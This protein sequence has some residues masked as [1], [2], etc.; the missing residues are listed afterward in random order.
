MTIDPGQFVVDGMTPSRVETPANEAELSDIVSAAHE[1]GETIIPS[2]GR[3]GMSLGN[4]PTGYNVAANLA[5]MNGIVEYEPAD[6]TIVV[7][8]GLTFQALQ[9]ELAKHGQWLPYDPAFDDRATIGGALATNAVGTIRG[10]V[11]GI[12][13]LT[14]GLKVVEAD[15][16]ITKSGGKVVKNVQG[17]DLVRLHTGALGTLGVIVE[18]AF[19]V[20]PKPA[21]HTAVLSWV[22]SL[23]TARS[24]GMSLFNGSFMP[25]K[26]TVHSGTTAHSAI[27]S[28]SGQS[29]DTSE[30]FLIE[31]HLAGG[32]K[33][34]RRQVD[35]V[36][37]LLGSEM[38]EGYEV[39]DNPDDLPGQLA[40]DA[41]DSAGNV[42]T[43]G[44]FKPVEAFNFSDRSIGRSESAASQ[45]HVA[46]G[47]VLS[48]WNVSNA[49]SFDLFA[50]NVRVD[51]HKS[52]ARLV[53]DRCPHEYKS[54]IDV[55]DG[56]G[57]ELEISRRMK[58]Q[59]DPSGTLNPGRFVA[60]I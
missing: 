41:L 48:S 35:E 18:A 13:D 46:T 36:T 55:W 6:L 45:L 17:F 9:A 33:T 40:L 47:T 19:K 52:G 57:Q 42:A 22:D 37:G 58:G 1:A 51:A 11:G 54:G 56:A 2:G 15:G 26:L 10:S 20:A 29:P 60:G 32:V 39:I 31:I 28:V 38:V 23:A 27:E 14:I 43:R 59:F 21:A 12:R 3:T 8:A 44:T 24:V 16:T 53:F 25:L 50:S 7:E 49:E 4:L 30:A 5:Q 34:V